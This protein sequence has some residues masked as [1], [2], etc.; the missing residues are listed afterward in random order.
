MTAPS[1]SSFLSGIRDRVSGSVVDPAPLRR[2]GLLAVALVVLLVIGRAFGPSA[3]SSSSPAA[4]RQSLQAPTEQV[5]APTSS[6]TV[7]RIGA[8]LFLMVGGG[9]ALVL[10]RRSS[11]ATPSEAALEV[12]G[13]HSLGPGQSLRLVSCGDEVLLLSVGGEGTRLLRHWPRATFG[14]ATDAPSF[15][16]VLA[17]AAPDLEDAPPASTLEVEPLEVAAD[18][19]PAENAALEVE[20]A[21]TFVLEADP[22]EIA[23]DLEVAPPSVI[24]WPTAGL[25]QFGARA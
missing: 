22:V 18:L 6:W 21:E 5:A 8:V 15:A 2:A 9:I 7:G 14:G 19:E 11:T 1:P 25:P 3:A 12:L 20:P 13:T 16:E 4:E 10:R 23:S 17:K 24:G